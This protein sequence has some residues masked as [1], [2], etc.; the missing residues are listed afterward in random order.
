MIQRHLT[1]SVK[2]VLPV[3]YQN[4]LRHMRRV[5]RRMR[6]QIYR[7]TGRVTDVTKE[8]LCWA[9]QEIG[10]REG[11]I[12][13][14]YSSLSR[15]GHVA[16]GADTVIDAFLEVLGPN[17]TLAMPT[18]AIIGGGQAYLS[19]NPLFD[20]QTTPST[21][22]KLTE[23][24]RQRPGARRSIHPTHSIAAMGPQAEYLTTGHEMASTPFGTETPFEKLL[25]V[26]AWMVCLGIDIHVLTLYHTFEDLAESFPFDPYITDTIKARV[27]DH[28]GQEKVVV[29]RV[30][31]P[32]KASYR[33]DQHKGVRDV[34]RQFYQARGILSEVRVGDGTIYALRAQDL[35]Y[36]LQ[37]M[38]EQ[39]IT[40]YADHCVGIELG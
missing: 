40:I 29:T 32:K 18:F 10:L 30:H 17:G 23:L 36:A 15:L 35:W 33:I 28:A 34:V 12:A 7:S 24:F 2:A 19:A 1:N 20:P 22:G 11:D 13:M 27:I 5:L 4:K 16:G 38:L 26:N 3:P 9:L 31:D 25:K 37:D 39:G 21:V 14:V 6:Y 8:D